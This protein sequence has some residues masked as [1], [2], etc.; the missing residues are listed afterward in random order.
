MTTK[1]RGSGRQRAP[2]RAKVKD[3]KTSGVLPAPM[4][5]GPRGGMLRRGNPG[6]RSGGRHRDEWKEECVA[7]LKKCKGLDVL[8]RIISGDIREIVAQGDSGP[9]WGE[10]KNSDR[11]KA[12]EMLAHYA[13]G[14]P[15]QPVSGEDG[16]PIEGTITLLFE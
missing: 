1:K 10:T 6:S 12:V 9:I 7:A 11:L 14:K 4:R 2:A 8:Q 15:V 16:G 3:R 13:Y 5:P